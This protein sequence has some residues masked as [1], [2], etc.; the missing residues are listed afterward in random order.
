MLLN[1][2]GKGCGRM[3]SKKPRINVRSI[4]LGYIKLDDGTI[5][6]QRV[7]VV[8]ARPV[9]VGS[10]FGVDF[11]LVVIS[12]ISPHPSEKVLEELKDKPMLEP[13]KPPPDSWR[14]LK[15]LDKEPAVEE[16]EYF[17]E[18]VGRY[19]IRV[20]IEPLMA[21]LNTGAKTPKGEPFYIVRWAPK[22]SWRK[23]D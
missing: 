23:E 18:E 7:A 12:G 3:V 15:I 14:Q 1:E 4:K 22:I 5:I 9:R 19:I 21:S 11:D 8:D 2:G 17:D 16:V 6:V 13:N 10:P 20:E